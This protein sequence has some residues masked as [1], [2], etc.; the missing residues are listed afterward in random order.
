M[1]WV[2]LQTIFSL[3]AVLGLMF[4][5]VYAMKR[6]LFG[7]HPKQQTSVPIDVLGYK[8][9]QPKYS[10]YVLSISGKGVV[11]GLSDAGMQTLCELDGEDLEAYTVSTKA[12]PAGP[13]EPIPS[14]LQYLKEN[15]GMVRQKTPV[16][17]P[18]S[19]NGAGR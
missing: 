15:M 17:T 19:R 8:L 4:G 14:F 5:V 1:G 10:V 18:R 6:W 2:L 9:L 7:S 11:V 16:K 12:S 13:L 3:C